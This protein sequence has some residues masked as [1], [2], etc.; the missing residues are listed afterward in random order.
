MSDPNERPDAPQQDAE[1]TRDETGRRVEATPEAER[2]AQELDV[3]LASVEGSGSGGRITVADVENAQQQIDT[4]AGSTETGQSTLSPPPDSQPP[5]LDD[6][7]RQYVV[8][9][10]TLAGPRDGDVPLKIIKEDGG[11]EEPITADT[12]PDNPTNFFAPEPFSGGLGS[13]NQVPVKWILPRPQRLL[14]RRLPGTN[15]PCRREECFPAR[16]QTD[17]G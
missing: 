17:I 3:D 12:F 4:T 6:I 11:V 1:S 7:Q 2:R 8:L 16:N 15:Q 13:G 5:S 14:P 9:K 10:A